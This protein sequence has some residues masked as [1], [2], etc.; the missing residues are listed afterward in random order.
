MKSVIKCL[1]NAGLVTRGLMKDSYLLEQFKY[2]WDSKVKSVNEK[3]MEIILLKR[4]FFELESL[5]LEDWQILFPCQILDVNEK[6][7]IDRVFDTANIYY[8][9]ENDEMSCEVIL[10]EEYL[11]ME[12]MNEIIRCLF[13]LLPGLELT[14]MFQSEKKIKD[15]VIETIESKIEKKLKE[16]HLVGKLKK[17][18]FKEIKQNIKEGFKNGE[19]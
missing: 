17:T 2:E 18:L 7:V 6:E 13:S 16:I 14:F 19:S 15:F 1:N 10:S 3:Q 4:Y 12:T 9:W 5:Y 11:A 8:D